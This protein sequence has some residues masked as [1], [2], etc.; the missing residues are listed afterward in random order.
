MDVHDLYQVASHYHPAA[1]GKSHS[2]IH[3]ANPAGD[4]AGKFDGV[5]D[6]QMRQERRAISASDPDPPGTFSFA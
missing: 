6:Q 1:G 3:A 4:S 2:S 5:W